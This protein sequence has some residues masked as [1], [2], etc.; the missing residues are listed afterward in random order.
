[1]PDGKCFVTGGLEGELDRWSWQ[2]RWRQERLREWS[3]DSESIIAICHLSWGHYWISLSRSGEID[4]MS[5]SAHTGSWRLPRPPRELGPL[6]AH[7][8]R[9]WVA[10]GFDQS[11]GLGE[12]GV[13]DII[14][15]EPP[16]GSA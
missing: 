7:P 10:V 12:R 4:L 1:M 16:A 14:E 6:T 5:G 2:G 13:V 8:D 15:I 9:S 11:K 3:Y